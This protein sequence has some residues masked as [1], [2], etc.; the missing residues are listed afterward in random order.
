[1]LGRFVSGS[2]LI[3]F[4]LCSQRYLLTNVYSHST[5][6][7][8]LS[9]SRSPSYRPGPCEVNDSLDRF[10]WVARNLSIAGRVR[11][12]EERWAYYFAFGN[13][14]FLLKQSP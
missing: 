2:I 9:E 4:S 3:F 11:H 14:P 5:D 10:I 13:A 7:I 12:L 8:A 6:I 1:M